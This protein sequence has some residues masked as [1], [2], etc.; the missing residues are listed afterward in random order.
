[1]SAYPTQKNHKGISHINLSLLKV[2][3][4]LILGVSYAG[5]AVYAQQD[6]QDRDILFLLNLYENKQYDL[7]LK[8]INILEFQYPQ[9]DYAALLLFL[10]GNIAYY[11]KDYAL[12]ETHYQQLTNY[13]LEP[14]MQ[15][16]V[17]INRANI[18]YEQ[19]DYLK[20]AQLAEQ[21]IAL[22]DDKDYRFQVER[23]LGKVNLALSHY[24]PAIEHLNLALRYQNNDPETLYQLLTVYIRQD[25]QEQAQQIAEIIVRDTPQSPYANRALAC[26]LDYL[27]AGNDSATIDSLE[28]AL[29]K[30]NYTATTELA[31]RFA[32]ND[33]L[34]QDYHQSLARLKVL[35]TTSDYAIYLKGLNLVQLSQPDQADSLFA[36][37]AQTPDA[38]LRILSWLEREKLAFT[39]SPESALD[40]IAAFIKAN[41][42]L[43]ELGEV[44]FQY[45][46]LLF[47]VQ[48]YQEAAS[49]LIKSKQY[50]MS[51][52]QHQI[53]QTMLG[54]IWFKAGNYAEAALA[55]NRYLNLF[56]RGRHRSHACY[57]LALLSLQNKDYPAVRDY[58]ALISASPDSLVYQDSLD[59]LKA[60]AEFQQGNYQ[61][62]IDLFL[63][64][65]KDSAVYPKTIY[66]IAQALFFLEDYSKASVFI[67]QARVDST[68]AFSVL[69]LEGNI[70]F[71]LKD[72]DLAL[73]T[74]NTALTKA[75]NQQ[76]R[77]ETLSYLALTYYRL[78]N[79]DKA[80]ELYLSLSAEPASPQAYLLMAARSAYHARDYRQALN[81]FI[82]FA[83]LYPDSPL[84]L[85]ACASI[86]SIHYNLGDYAQAT[87]EWI[88]LLQHFVAH[89]AFD[90]DELSILSGTF[91]GLE[92]G[93]KQHYDEHLID[94]LAVLSDTF[95]SDYIKF[96]LQYLLLKVYAGNELWSDLLQS[97]DAIRKEFPQKDNS[98]I[99]HLIASAY[100]KLGHYSEADTTYKNVYQLDPSPDILTEW[101][102]LN[103]AQGNAAEA[104]AKLEQAYRQ[105]PKSE[106]L[107]TLFEALAENLPD[108]LDTYYKKW[109]AIVTPLPEQVLLIRLKY[110]VDNW[111]PAEADSLCALLINSSITNIRAQAQLTRGIAAFLQQHYEQA[112]LEL[113]RTIY[114]YADY[115]ELVLTAK[116]YLIRTYLS[117][118][119]PNEAR[120][121]Y[122]EIEAKLSA[123]QLKEFTP[124]FTAGEQH[125]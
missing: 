95:N 81:L 21:L 10:R 12:A 112:I 105:E 77:T 25:N 53:V 118:N 57:N 109:S 17:L 41:D 39:A 54:D 32:H 28:V 73:T 67:N 2:I 34:K 83:T 119:L 13:P 101:A 6:K 31:L 4:L 72:Y 20:A 45:G 38:Q 33:F 29:P 27:L 113:L 52:L 80:R 122:D 66:R 18:R 60:E 93:L 9:S 22:T 68:T 124:Y 11:K 55:Y 98:Q 24:Q 78:R 69:L 37:L 36:S 64:V 58:A 62:A 63:S 114:L 97:A 30:H 7:A 102:E 88:A 8:Q 14:A 82:Q 103:L 65:A 49:A 51:D 19:Q 111:L 70:Y 5:Q 121:Y 43:P 3:L 85:N 15:L 96:E 90:D 16:E 108:S 23:L 47:Q 48:R 87:N 50:P 75:T 117:Q 100:S 120:P 104:I 1:M 46:T 107:I 89:N 61:T 71:N 99:Q 56:P 123:D 40:Q 44:L 125:E 76:D 74:Y 116:L 110:A 94:S 35:E 26:W 84:Y 42:Q 91:R 59:Y 115:Q 79:F 92:W 86:A 106:R